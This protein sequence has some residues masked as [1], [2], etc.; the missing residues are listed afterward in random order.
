MAAVV[1]GSL[2]ATS[3]LVRVSGGSSPLFV[4]VEAEVQKLYNL[5]NVIVYVLVEPRFESGPVCSMIRFN[6]CIIL[7]WLGSTL[8]ALS[9][10]MEEDPFFIALEMFAIQVSKK[11]VLCWMNEKNLRKMC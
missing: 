1:L 9:E 6:P 8:T 5:S 2:L 4:D 3:V 10:N 11:L 7:T